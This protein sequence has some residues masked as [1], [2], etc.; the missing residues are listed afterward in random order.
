MISP[1][2][3]A[4][5]DNLAGSERP[6]TALHW[7]GKSTAVILRE[8]ATGQRPLTHAALDELPDS[9]PLRHLRTILVAMAS[10]R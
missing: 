2:L 3:Q 6:A 7:L 10:V 5:H 9:K 4:L 1:A 8:L